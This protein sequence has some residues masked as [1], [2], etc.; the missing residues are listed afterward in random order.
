MAGDGDLSCAYNVPSVFRR[1]QFVNRRGA[2]QFARLIE[3]DI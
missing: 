2:Q 1:I 3:A